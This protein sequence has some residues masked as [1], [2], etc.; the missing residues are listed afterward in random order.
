[1]V[2]LNVVPDLSAQTFLNSF[3]RFT[4]RRGFPNNMISDNGKTFKS[5]AK[6][7][8]NLLDHP[9]VKRHFSQI[10]VTWL[11]NLER[12]PW[13]GGFFER[14]NKSMKRCLKKT[15]RNA[16]LTF[17]ELLTAVTEVEMILNSRPLLY[18]STD[19]M[20]EP[21]TPSHLLIGRRVLTLPMY[22][23]HEDL[24]YGLSPSSVELTRRMH[25]F[26]KTLDQFWKRWKTEY[27]VE[28]RECHRYH[29]RTKGVESIMSVG[30]LVLVH[31]QVCPRGL[32]KLAIIESVI[33][34][35]DSHI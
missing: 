2:H 11:F 1:M 33:K 13:W 22:S 18:V 23:P 8:K 16:R 29:N 15:I 17:D 27:L 21:L 35:S 12:A 9:E 10:S 6:T 34:G 32:W 30:D 7:I 20:E 3:K 24:D 25:H 26:N 5:A 4:A 28:F 31:D 19:D 14:L